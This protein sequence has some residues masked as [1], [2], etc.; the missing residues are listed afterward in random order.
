MQYLRDYNSESID[1]CSMVA[2]VFYSSFLW[3][4]LASSYQTVRDKNKAW[5]FLIFDFLCKGLLVKHFVPVIVIGHFQT[6][7]VFKRSFSQHN[8]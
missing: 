1:N 7:T 8:Q 4:S 6:V 3:G 2:K 5:Q